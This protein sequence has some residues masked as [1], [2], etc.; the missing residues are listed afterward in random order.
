MTK[1]YVTREQAPLSVAILGRL[2]DLQEERSHSGEL[3]E[4][5][6]RRLETI[7]GEVLAVL[8]QIEA[9]LGGHDVESLE[10]ST[11]AAVE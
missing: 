5:Y 7:L 6:Y 3:P 2:S 9:A 10:S 4:N 11:P 8:S 1:A